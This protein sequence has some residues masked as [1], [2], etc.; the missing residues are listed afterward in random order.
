[1]NFSKV[2]IHGGHSGEFCHHAKDRLEDCVLAY[3]EQ[4]FQ[5]VGITEH[6]PP[7]NN[8]LR[9]PDEI[10]A[11]LD[12]KDLRQKF[13]RYM[14]KAR[15]LQKKY[16][17]DIQLFIGFE[18]E[19]YSGYI[20]HV[21]SLIQEYHPDYVVGSVHHVDD[22]NFDYSPDYYEKAVRHAGGMVPLYAR[23]FDIQYEMIQRL[24]PRVIGH[25]DVIRLYDPLYQKHLEMPEISKRIYRN[26][27]V[28]RSKQM[29]LDFNMRAL[30][31]GAD[32]PYVSIGILKIAKLMGIPIVPGDDSHSV[33]TV[34]LNI[35]TGIRLLQEAGVSMHWPVI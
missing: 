12:Y 30:L 2:S 13:S 7:P 15:Y 28:I 6:I 20:G 29:I 1:M 4:N 32:E 33:D 8:E 31:K 19:A 16:Q 3:I 17:D 11:H 34:G 27:A 14:K 21:T 35:E 25:F 5:W 9:Y 22:I 10:E 23:Y 26:L 24:S 18:T